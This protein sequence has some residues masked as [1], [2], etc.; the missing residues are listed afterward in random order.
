MKNIMHWKKSPVLVALAAIAFIVSCNKDFENTLPTPDSDSIV[1]QNSERKT[2]LIIVD[3]AVGTEVKAAALPN[4]IQLADF[5]IHSFDGLADYSQGA[6][7]NETGWSNLLTGVKPDKHLVAGTD[8]S[9]NNFAN[10]P[11]IFTHLKQV[12]PEWRTSA[13]AASQE[14][15]DYIAE[16]ATEKVAFAG[17]D[18]AVKD[19]VKNE[20]ATKDPVFLLA[21]FHAVDEAGK[22]GDYSVS[23]AGYKSALQQMDSYIGEIMTSLRAR[24]SFKSENW[25]VIITSNKGSNVAA[26]P[27]AAA[28]NAYN[29]S[30]RNTFFLCYN[31]R[32]NSVNPA[33]PGTVIPYIGTAPLYDGNNAASKSEVLDGGTTYDFGAEGSFTIQCKVKIKPGGYYYPA[34]L[35]KRESFDGGVPGW[36]FFLEGDVWQINFGQTG[37]GNTQVKGQS[38]TD[39]NW[40]TLTAVIRQEGTNRMVYTYTDG[41]YSGNSANIAGKGNINS[42][43]PLT[44]GWIDG[45]RY[46]GGYSPTGY[47]VTDVRIYN[48]ALTEEYIAGNFCKIN[49]ADTDPYFNSLIG[50]WP[51]TSVSSAKEM[52]DLSGNNHPMVVDLLNSS[53]FTE[54][55]TEVCPDISEEVYRTVPNSVDVASQIYRWYGILVPDN[56]SLDGKIWIPGYAD[57]SG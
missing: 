34:F 52:A 21:Q 7:T 33:R 25:M 47:Y 8:L 32:F 54:L 6:M 55:S 29:D 15:V 12:K 39:N 44:V 2:L 40:H 28:R 1:L 45:S 50:F 42:P 10:Y 43:A 24:P 37:Q 46:G 49:I 5:S 48:T 41:V 38:I 53:N 4:I 31:P 22:A 27:D 18:A 36:V 14:V 51:C 17:D 30:R 19:A 35:G 20:L 3:G 56:W 26:D 9:Q 11:S 13:F 57:V 16:D 23:D